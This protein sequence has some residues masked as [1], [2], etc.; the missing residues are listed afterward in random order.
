MAEPSLSTD[1]ETHPQI[2]HMI[3]EELNTKGSSTGAMADS[4]TGGAEPLASQVEIS[5]DAVK[6]E[7]PIATD[8]E[9]EGQ[10]VLILCGLIASG[11]VET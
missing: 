11:K 7:S 5:E 4:D 6:D 1:A 8:F 2:K 10:V 3:V 9:V